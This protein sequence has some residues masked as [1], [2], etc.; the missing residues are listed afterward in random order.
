MPN[1]TTASHWTKPELGIIELM[2]SKKNN[3]ILFDPAY[4]SDFSPFLDTKP[5]VPA[6]ERF[7]ALG[8]TMR[9]GLAAFVS[10][11]GHPLAQ[12]AGRAGVPAD[13]EAQLRLAEP[14]LLQ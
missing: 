4:S 3:V 1:R 5:G 2:G 14:G 10:G 12:A 13:Q 9:S 8:G 6:N 7:K 11:D